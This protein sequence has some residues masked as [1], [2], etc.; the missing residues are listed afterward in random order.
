MW[1][2][3][4]DLHTFSPMFSPD[5][6][7]QKTFSTPCGEQCGEFSIITVMR[8][9]VL[10]IFAVQCRLSDAKRLFLSAI[11]LYFR[12]TVCG[13]KGTNP[14]NCTCIGGTFPQKNDKN[15]PQR[16]DQCAG[17]AKM[18]FWERLFVNKV[19]FPHFIH[20]KYR[21][22]EQAFCKMQFEIFLF[23]KCFSRFHSFHRLYSYYFWFCC[24]FLC[25]VGSLTEARHLAYRQGSGAYHT[26]T[27]CPMFYFTDSY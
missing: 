19:R 10:V 22:F 18:A 27:A 15:Y 24:V 3:R 9:D 16:H 7:S 2:T 1:K 26:L 17:G 11:L 23:H 5:G 25:Y 8:Q 13:K 20:R 4:P 21:S 14:T 12:K 6:K